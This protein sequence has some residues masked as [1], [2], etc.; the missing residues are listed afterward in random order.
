MAFEGFWSQ[1]PEIGR[2]REL[3][4]LGLSSVHEA[5]ADVLLPFLS[6]RTRTADEYLWVLIGLRWSEGRSASEAEIWDGFEAFEKALK[7]SWYHSGRRQ[8]FTGVDAIRGHYEAGRRDFNFNLVSLQR[9]QGLLGAYIQ[10]L[11]KSSLV[12]PRS[13][14]PTKRG[15]ALIGEI[16]F[17]WN[18]KISGYGWLAR[19]FGEAEKRFSSSTHRDLGSALFDDERMRD[20]ATA[21]YNLGAQPAWFGASRSLGGSNDK[22][23]VATIGDELARFS[24]QMTK[25]FW[26][27]LES[28]SRTVVRLVRRRLR[29]P[30]WRDVVFRSNGLRPFRESFDRFLIDS[31]SRPA[32]ALIALHTSVWDRRGHVAPWIRASKGNIRVR[33]DIALKVPPVERDWDLRWGVAHGLIRRTRWRPS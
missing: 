4:P 12:E 31:G 17:R 9:S 11:R 33:P 15:R 6:G 21:I 18:G 16:V 26:S 23:L 1:P 29:S 10:S 5:A 2:S 13:L 14:R 28:P 8:G 30:K 22:R 7:L 32:A 27:L 24:N 3:D 20:V 19:T 25:T